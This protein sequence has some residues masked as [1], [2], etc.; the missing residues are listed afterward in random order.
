MDEWS[1]PPRPRDQREAAIMPIQSDRTA[2]PPR[3][4][5]DKNATRRSPPPSP[6]PN[7]RKTRT[8]SGVRWHDTAFQGEARLAFQKH[9]F[10]PC[11]KTAR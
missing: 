3:R 4:F 7:H 5:R 8:A 1:S 2:T 9:Q 6:S 11:R 10:A